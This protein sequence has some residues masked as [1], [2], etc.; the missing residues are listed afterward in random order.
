MKENWE[1]AYKLKDMFER[2]YSN[3]PGDPG[4]ETVWGIARNYHLGWSGWSLVDALRGKQ[5]FRNLVA[6]NRKIKS[7]A[8]EYFRKTFWDKYAC[9]ELPYPLDMIVWDMSVNPSREAAGKMLQAC[10]NDLGF[11]LK[12]DDVIGPKTLS[13]VKE[14]AIAATGL[15]LLAAFYLLRRTANYSMRIRERSSQERFYKGWIRQRV[16]NLAVETEVLDAQFYIK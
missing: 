2:A 6:T 12:A 1:R 3:T 11:S 8:K 9:D 7:E 16:V 15:R 10:L 13:A 14:S 4:G 5:D